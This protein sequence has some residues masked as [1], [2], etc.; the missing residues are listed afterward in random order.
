VSPRVAAPA[1]FL[2]AVTVAV[3]LVRAGLRHA[4]AATATTTTV[5]T[6]ASPPRHRVAAPAPTRR[7][8]I[9]AKGDTLDSLARAAGIGVA[10]LEA[11]NPG[12]DPT[13]LRVGERIRVK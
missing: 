10:Q 7:Y 1:A 6:H 4:P 12:V 13:A 3:L 5:A 8:V 9:V 11:L 2:L